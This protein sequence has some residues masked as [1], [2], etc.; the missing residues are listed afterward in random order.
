MGNNYLKLS[1]LIDAIYQKCNE[2]N[3]MSQRERLLSATI[4]LEQVIAR[5]LSLKGDVL[6]YLNV[7][8]SKLHFQE[9]PNLIQLQREHARSSDRIMP[10]SHQDLTRIESLLKQKEFDRLAMPELVCIFQLAAEKANQNRK[11]PIILDRETKRRKIL[12]LHWGEIHY[13]QIQE[14]LNRIDIKYYDK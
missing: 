1:N 9:D 5:N 11:D 7:L 10:A 3:T 6:K 12:L 8:N 14:H 13:D 2:E 4:T